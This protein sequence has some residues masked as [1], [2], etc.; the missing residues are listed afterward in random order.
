MRRLLTAATMIA[1]FAVSAPA[2]AYV[3][4]GLYLYMDARNTDSYS[5]SNSTEW[6]DISVNGRNGTINGSVTLDGPTDA[7]FFDGTAVGT[8]YVDLDGAFDNW[9]TGFTIEFIGEFG[10][11]V[12]N[13]ERI[14]DFGNGAASDNIWVGRLYGTNDLTLEY[15]IG[16]S[17]QGRCHTTGGPLSGRELHH[18]IITVDANA[19]CRIYQ[20]G[21]EVETSLQDGGGAHVSGPTS[22]GTQYAALPLN[23]ARTNNFVGAS[24]WPDRDFEGSIQ[25]IRIYTRALTVDDVNNADETTPTESGSGGGGGID[26]S[27]GGS[28]ANTGFDAVS[29]V[30]LAAALLAGGLLLVRRRHQN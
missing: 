12:D 28:L 6:N 11:N 22:D 10:A 1:V 26:E 2:N 17:N 19:V 8:N 29:S 30:V 23:V 13:W 3:T 5:V 21:L 9:G 14:F 7:L 24:N 25:M 16:S 18:W 27:N 15:F 4:D 20:D